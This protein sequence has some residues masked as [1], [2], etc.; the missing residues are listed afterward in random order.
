VNHPQLIN[1]TPIDPWPGGATDGEDL[2]EA[3]AD[4]ITAHMAKI[5][6]RH[7]ALRPLYWSASN[8]GTI[9][10]IALDYPEHEIPRLL[11]RWAQALGLPQT[12]PD[13]WPERPWY[14]GTIDGWPIELRDTVDTAARYAYPPICS[15]PPLGS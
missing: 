12:P 6:G 15:A 2:R 3:I 8:T 9:T 11:A 14:T 10:G 1:D 5:T 4:A 13:T 7:A